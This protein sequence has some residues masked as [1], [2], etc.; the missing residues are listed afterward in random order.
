MSNTDPRDTERSNPSSNGLSNGVTVHSTEKGPVEILEPRE[1]PLGGPRAMTVHRSLPQKARSLVGAWC[2]LDAYGPDRV[3]DSGGMKVARHP[4]TGLAT[5]SWLF[6]GN[7]DH[8]DSAGNWATVR[9]GWV[10]LMNAG[11]GI[12]HSEYSSDTTEVLHGLQLWYA[13][14]D[15]HRFGEPR[16]DS[17]LPP[18][19]EG[20]GYTARVFL[21]SLLG[22]TSP[23]ETHI[24]LTGAEFRLDAGATLE[25]PV[26]QDHEHGIIQVT[27]SISLDGV[28]VPENAIGV[29]P[30]G[31]S[32]L[33]L[34]AGSEPVTAVLIGGEPLGEQ[35]V[36]WWNFVGRTHEEIELWRKRYMQEMG[37]DPADE[38]SPVPT[39]ETVGE[40]LPTEL[41]GESYQDDDTV[42]PQFGEFP[43]NQPTPIPAPQLPN[44]R[45][46]LRG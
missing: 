35:I 19:I 38:S 22:S 23:V 26:P 16:L 6:E 1:V 33:T 40:V 45:L 5:V 14:P 20:E 28:E 43:P 10:N 13:L 46:R 29:A 25:I 11:K 4:H 27:G 30:T 41:L 44:A 15:E 42:Y 31:R 36:M 37:F 7:I 17:Y 39:G 3:S 12:T 32:A 34:T 9:P 2:F 18:L 24:P 8:I 21:G